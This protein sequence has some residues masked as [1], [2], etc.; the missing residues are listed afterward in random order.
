MSD[1]QTIVLDEVDVMFL[2]ETFDLTAIGT[3]APSGTQFLFVTATLPASVAD[4]V[5]MAV[6]TAGLDTS[7]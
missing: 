3:S 4:Q 1:V 6:D 2:D 7:N 5:G